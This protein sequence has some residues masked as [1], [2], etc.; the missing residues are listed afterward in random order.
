M[1]N[2]CDIHQEQ[3]KQV[4]RYLKGTSHYMI[5]YGGKKDNS[6]VLNGYWDAD[7]AGILQQR[8]SQ[9]RYMFMMN[10]AAISW[11][12]ERQ[13]TTPLSTME[14]EYMALTV[15]SQEATFLRQLLQ[16]MG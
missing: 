16:D 12:S 11:K 1:S 14:A 15:A 6:T 2:P 5:Q 13:Q 9:T 10:G 7:F 3:A 8:G 4:L